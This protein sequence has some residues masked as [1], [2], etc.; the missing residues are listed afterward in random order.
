MPPTCSNPLL[1]VM[2]DALGEGSGVPRE[3]IVRVC[4]LHCQ[5]CLSIDSTLDIVSCADEMFIASKVE[6]KDWDEE[7]FGMAAAVPWRAGE[8]RPDR[9]DAV[10]RAAAG[11]L[12]ML[13]IRCLVVALRVGLRYDDEDICLL[14]STPVSIVNLRQV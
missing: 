11:L 8:V 14:G 7:G 13:G 1:V 4:S 2:A 9:Y 6:V 12:L 5:R 10:P 3:G